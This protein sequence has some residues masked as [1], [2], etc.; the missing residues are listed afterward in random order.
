MK[1]SRRKDHCR[2]GRDQ[3]PRRRRA[4]IIRKDR[5][6]LAID[7]SSLKAHIQMDSTLVPSTKETMVVQIQVQKEE[8]PSM[9]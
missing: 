8:E 3:A 1:K 9:G 6:S 5:E 7:G 4:Q 2:S